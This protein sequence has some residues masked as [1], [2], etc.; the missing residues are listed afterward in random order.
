MDRCG[1]FRFLV[2]V[3]ALLSAVAAD[4]QE[5]TCN[6]EVRV[7]ES[8]DV[9]A[10]IGAKVLVKNLQSGKVL[11]S[12]EQFDKYTFQNLPEGDYEI[13]A[14]KETYKQS[15]YR[16]K[17]ICDKPETEG[18][19][20]FGV[21][22]RE[23]ES[24]EKVVVEQKNEGKL[25][26]TAVTDSREARLRKFAQVNKILNYDAVSLAKPKYPAA[27]RAVSAAGVVYVRVTVNREGEV[28]SAQA[29]SGHPLLGAEAVKAARETKFKPSLVSDSPG[30]ITG[31]I[32]YNFVP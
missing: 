32:I 25:R 27:A 21:T 29:V 3:V 11:D 12:G 4:G 9:L 19:V 18:Y 2:L 7:F 24:N 5:K 22:L 14:S 17:L 31:F 15:V 16:H 26:G 1:I 13:S 23:G 8:Q 30:E 6:L 10:L 28:V 20:V